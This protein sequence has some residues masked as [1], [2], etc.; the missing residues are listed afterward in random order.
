MQIRLAKM[1]DVQSIR[2]ILNDVTLQLI[3]KAFRNGIIRGMGS[4]FS[5]K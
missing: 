2:M 1:E 5:D 3:E 4:K